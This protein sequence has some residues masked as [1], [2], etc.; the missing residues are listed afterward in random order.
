MRLVVGLPDHRIIQVTQDSS[1]PVDVTGRY[2]IE[3]PPGVPCPALTPDSYVLNAG[4]IDAGSVTGP[5]YDGLLAQYPQYQHILYNNFLN[6]Q[7]VADLSVQPTS[8]VIMAT[9]IYPRFQSGRSGGGWPGSAPNSTAL[10]PQNGNQPGFLLTVPGNSRTLRPARTLRRTTG[11][12][13]GPTN[14]RPASLPGL[15]PGPL[16]CWFFCLM[17]AALRGQGYRG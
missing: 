1:T 16:M 6:A 17:T 10:L 2:V 13:P 4:V 12:W 14:R 9:T 5:L 11:S 7:D 3:V 8:T 15:T